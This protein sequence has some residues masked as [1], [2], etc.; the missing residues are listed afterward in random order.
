MPTLATMFKEKDLFQNPVSLDREG[1]RR[2]HLYVNLEA[3]EIGHTEVILT[4][5]TGPW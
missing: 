4:E 3:N 1:K 5:K 2:G